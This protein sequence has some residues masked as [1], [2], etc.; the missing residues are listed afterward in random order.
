LVSFDSIV[1]Q[2]HIHSEFF[3]RLLEPF[4]LGLKDIAHDQRATLSSVVGKIDINRT[5]GNLS[6]ALRLFV[7]DH[8]RSGNPV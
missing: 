2:E 5:Q 3:S 4:W 6:S 1:A 8:A 7:L